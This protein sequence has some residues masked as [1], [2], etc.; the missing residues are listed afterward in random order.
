MDSIESIYLD[1]LLGFLS[2][3][4]GDMLKCEEEM[5]VRG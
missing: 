3:F 1:F 2:G 5:V 4:D